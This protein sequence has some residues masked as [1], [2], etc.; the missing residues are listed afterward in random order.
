MSDKPQFVDTN[1]LIYA[2]DRSAGAKHERARAVLESLWENGNGRL[3]IQVLQEFYTNA[4]RKI[5][6][7]LDADTAKDI[8]A[9]FGEWPTHS[10]TVADVLA[11]IELQKRHSLSFWDAMMLTSA[12]RM[13]CEAVLSEDLSAGQDYDGVKVVNPFEGG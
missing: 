13:G 6:K 1:V 9:S 8:I 7:P 5:S 2:H 10:P 12:A 3:S 4:T 11:A